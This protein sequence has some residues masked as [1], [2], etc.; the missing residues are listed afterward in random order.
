MTRLDA[1]NDLCKIIHTNS[2]S[3][4]WISKKAARVA[5]GRSK[6]GKINAMEEM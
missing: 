5:S 4:M 6:L 1:V 2:T 3:L